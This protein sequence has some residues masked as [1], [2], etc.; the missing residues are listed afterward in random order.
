MQL[1]PLEKEERELPETTHELS[2]M[3][4]DISSPNPE[5]PEQSL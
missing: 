2:K 3:R 1:D 4:P 5:V